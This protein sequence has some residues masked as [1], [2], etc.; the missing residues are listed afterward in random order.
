M[1]Y[2][3]TR[4]ILKFKDVDYY[5]GI[6]DSS[7]GYPYTVSDV[8]EAHDFLSEVRAKDYIKMF[9]KSSSLKI[10]PNVIRCVIYTEL[11]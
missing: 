10:E 6:G 4:F 3:K 8:L 9:S 2:E 5:V 1:K 7:G 11:H